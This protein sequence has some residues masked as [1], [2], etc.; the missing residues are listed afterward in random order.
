MFDYV[1][2]QIKEFCIPFIGSTIISITC[3]YYLVCDPPD[4]TA[5]IDFMLLP[6]TVIFYVV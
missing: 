4:D 5:M 2:K 1:E 6:T 3:L